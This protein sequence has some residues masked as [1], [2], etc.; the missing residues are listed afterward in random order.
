M[1]T[2]TISGCANTVAGVPNIKCFMGLA[3]FVP[4]VAILILLF[5]IL[6]WRMSAEPTRERLAASTFAVAIVGMLESL[7]GFLPTF[8]MVIAVGC[9]ILN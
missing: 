9:T 5:G 7:A 2:D 6:Y 8:V 1:V 3:N 4:G